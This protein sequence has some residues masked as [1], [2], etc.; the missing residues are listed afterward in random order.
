M[1]K[2]VMSVRIEN[3]ECHPQK[4]FLF[5]DGTYTSRNEW[6]EQVFSHALL[7]T[8]KEL[9]ECLEAQVF[10]E[11]E[12]VLV[13]YTTEEIIELLKYSSVPL[14]WINMP[15]S[16][17]QIFSAKA[18]I[19]IN[20]KMHSIE[21]SLIVIQQLKNSQSKR[22]NW[23]SILEY[24]LNTVQVPTLN[25][26]LKSIV[27]HGTLQDL[28]HFVQDTVYQFDQANLP[29]EVYAGYL[30][31][32]YSAFFELSRAEYWIHTMRENYDSD[33]RYLESIVHSMQPLVFFSK[34]STYQ[35]SSTRDLLQRIRSLEVENQEI[36]VQIE[37]EVQEFLRIFELMKFERRSEKAKSN[38]ENIPQFSGKKIAV[39]GDSGRWPVYRLFLEQEGAIP[40]FIPGFEKIRFG[41]EHFVH[42]DGVLFI[43][44]YSSH[45]LY[46]ALKARRVLP[47]TV[48]IDRA[49]IQAFQEGMKRLHQ[50]L[51]EV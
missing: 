3:G 12:D 35:N 8:V 51:D 39:V 5:Q 23:Q 19:P 26:N 42:V 6:L 31:A 38:H 49:G 40:I 29:N 9:Q 16:L 2:F 25:C 32:S 14:L 44:A 41:I 22:L 13:E 30:F 28:H 48:L 1:E 33:F 21:Q 27:L 37:A 24:H 43:T 15:Q 46:Y 34:K 36:K 20:R 4:P 10:K 50:I 47:N 18:I 17:R 45:S 7:A 11:D